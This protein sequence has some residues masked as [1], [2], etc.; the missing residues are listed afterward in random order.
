VL[1]I[2]KLNELDIAFQSYKIGL[3]KIKAATEQI[4]DME[5]ELGEEEKLLKA[6]QDNADKL[7]IDLGK[8]T[9]KANKK[10][11][12]VKETKDRCQ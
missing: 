1:Y 5:V 12:E 11:A 4:R 3:D 9:E 7:L 10:G 6:A 8:Q 2:N